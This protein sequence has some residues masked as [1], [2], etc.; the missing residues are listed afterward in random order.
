MKI[1]ILG[2]PGSGKTFI[3]LH[4][5]EK[6]GVPRFDL[7]DLFWDRDAN[8]YGVRSE[9]EKRDAE[10]RSIV[11]RESWII[12]GVYFAWLRRSFERAD[13]IVVLTPSVWLRDWRVLRRFIKR[14]LGMVPAKKESLLD[15]YRLIEWNHG[16]DRDN[17]KRTLDFI[18]GF[19]SKIVYCG[20]FDQVIDEIEK[21]KL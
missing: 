13:I 7:D 9:P 14:K 21:R 12:E 5:S 1:H 11:N 8:R 17:L 18:K 16:Y 6:Y 20:T 15:F 2:G 10:L 19:E 4:I 3:A